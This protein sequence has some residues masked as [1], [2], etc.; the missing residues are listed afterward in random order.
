MPE[1]TLQQSLQQVIQLTL[2][3]VMQLLLLACACGVLVLRVGLAMTSAG[4]CRSKNAA[5]AVSRVLT[6]LLVIALAFYLIGAPILL[7]RSNGV[8]GFDY[9]VLAGG[10][11]PA[12]MFWMMAFLIAGG[13]VAGALHERSRSV[14]LPWLSGVL[15]ALVLPIMG[16]W[17]WYG[18][19]GRNGFVD[20]AGASVIHFP[21]AV[22]AFIG[23]W[24]IGPRSGKYNHDGSA[25]GIPG[26]NVPLAATGAIV[27]LV[28][29]L[30][31]VLGAMLIQGGFVELLATAAANVILGAA[32]GGVAA[33]VY[34]R[35]RY[36]K[37]E[38]PLTLTGILA[39]MVAVSACGSLVPVWAAIILGAVAAVAA[40]WFSLE[41][42]FRWH[43]DD[44]AAA[45]SSHG[46]GAIVGTVG[47]SFFMAGGTSDFLRHLG[48]QAL[49]LACAGVLAAV[50]A[51][52]TLLI[53]RKVTGLRS[54]EADE[55]D[56]LDLAEHDINAYPDFQQ[57]MIKSY[58]L[59][60]A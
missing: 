27:T 29:W 4:I 31:Y 28:G 1:A 35:T 57:T 60:E 33:M 11:V 30:P 32:A 44:P 15:A 10:M 2:Q 36:G 53:L 52:G 48:I 43:I 6:D 46:V 40:V 26:H 45:I 51:G 21:A 25:N 47:I 41:L 12:A 8:L 3:Q 38:L 55:Y 23:A 17:V 19:L 5:S 58:H 20:V 34:A 13:V 37:P 9:H 59:R 7:Q 39:A 54:S 49:G 24:L 18:W 42:E 50:L 56:G 16:H 22:A 14:G